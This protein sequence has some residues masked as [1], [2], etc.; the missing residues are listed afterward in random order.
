MGKDLLT[1]YQQNEIKRLARFSLS[2]LQRTILYGSSLVLVVLLLG[3]LARAPN[4]PGVNETQRRE[5]ARSG[6]PWAESL[7]IEQELQAD[8][9]AR[10]GIWLEQ[11]I[12]ARVSY[13]VLEMSLSLADMQRG[14]EEPGFFSRVAT[15]LLAGSLRIGFLLIA[16][17][18]LLLAFGLWGWWSSRRN[19]R[20]YVADDA[21]GQTGNGRLF[22][23]GVSVNLNNRDNDG[24]PA[25]QVAGLAC[26]QRAPDQVV[27]GSSLLRTLERFGATND[28]N[29]ALCAIILR[30]KDHPDHIPFAEDQS[31]FDH[32]YETGKLGPYVEQILAHVLDA[33]RRIL[34]EQREEAGP[35]EQQVAGV[36]DSAFATSQEDS[37]QSRYAKLVGS[38]L[39][40]VLSPR[41]R[42]AATAVSSS[43]VATLCLALEAGKIMVFAVEG[44][45]WNRRSHFPELSARAILHSCPEFSAAYNAMI[46]SRLRRAL[47][48]SGD[49]SPFAP[50]RL[51]RDLSAEN[52]ALLSFSRILLS[53]PHELQA[54]AAHEELAGLLG[55]VHVGFER[56]F[57]ASANELDPDLLDDAYT[58]NNV[59]L[60]RLPKLMTLLRQV[61]DSALLAR[62]HKLVATVATLRLEREQTDQSLDEQHSKTHGGHDVLLTPLRD[63]EISAIATQFRLEEADVRDWG[64]LRL[65]LYHFGWLGRR[66]SERTVPGS[67]IVFAVVKSEHRSDALS[68]LEAVVPLRATRCREQWGRNWTSRFI[69]VE[70]AR[71]AESR[72]DYERLLAGEITDVTPDDEGGD[73]ETLVGA[74]S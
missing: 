46:R 70:W 31:K 65:A 48:F 73:D 7:A 5:L 59:L 40:G 17:T 33:H 62:L 15:A 74:V 53:V 35:T 32:S 68:G 14:V 54:R 44:G 28:L 27:N 56:I 23:S 20:P 4:D 61:I 67:S 13:Q 30:Y 34:E 39:Y 19:A 43:E 57:F 55:H 64:V 6:L 22:F 12:F 72:R 25:Q 37:F 45:Q 21:L 18:R 51:P 41:V 16:A 3:A 60:L 63:E 42:A 29:R 69:Q 11:G 1:E 66:V 47:V 71:I 38:I 24:S 52:R 50:M 2:P 58:A 9:L 26:P 10:R 49:A 36:D 8:W